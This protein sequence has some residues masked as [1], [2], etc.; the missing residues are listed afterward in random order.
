MVCFQ[1]LHKYGGLGIFCLSRLCFFLINSFIEIEIYLNTQPDFFGSWIKGR[2]YDFATW[3]TKVCEKISYNILLV[4]K[5]HSLDWLQFHITSKTM[6][7]KLKKYRKNRIWRHD[8]MN[9]NFSFINLNSM[10]KY[11]QRFIYISLNYHK[12]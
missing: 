10:T 12:V 2:G 4:F 3:V 7:I 9:L 6:N 8:L 11:L 1:T 5:I